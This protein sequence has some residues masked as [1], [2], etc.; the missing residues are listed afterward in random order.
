MDVVLV[1]LCW[2]SC[3]RTGLCDGLITR[4]KESYL[5]S[6]YI[7]KSPVWGGQGPFKD[8]GATEKE[9]EEEIDKEAESKQN[10][11]E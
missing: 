10:M 1:F 5:V 9:E 8:C 11:R 4:P 3:V 6:K 2:L 7:K